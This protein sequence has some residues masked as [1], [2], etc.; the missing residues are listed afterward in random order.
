[1]KKLLATI[2]FISISIAAFSQKI[3]MNSGSIDFLKDEKTILA[4]FTYE[5]M[6]VG[7]MSEADYIKDKTAKINTKDPGKGDEWAVNWVKDRA[8][9]FE[10][11]FAELFNKRMIEKNGVQ[12]RDEGRYTI[13]VNTYFSEPGW[14]V[15]VSRRNASVS[16]TCT[17]IDN[18]TE[19][20]VA[21]I[22]VENASANDFWGTDFDT[23]Y[24]LQESYG[25]AGRELAAFI[26]KRLKL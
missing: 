25:K 18:E 17:F 22:T 12:I 8:E 24:R 4:K 5:D 2:L 20:E 11:K 3:K 23:G 21:I 13:L 26:A 9:R 19:K 15:G 7:K 1:M 14:N 16:V 6:T 10:P